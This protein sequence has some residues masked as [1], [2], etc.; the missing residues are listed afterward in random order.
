MDFLEAM[1]D[2]RIAA[3][4]DRDYGESIF[5][6]KARNVPGVV[7]FRFT[8]ASPDEAGRILSDILQERRVALAGKFTVVERDRIR[9]RSLGDKKDGRRDN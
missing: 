4:F 2:G 8:P 3:T 9:Q 6:Y 7:Y 5:R 1:S